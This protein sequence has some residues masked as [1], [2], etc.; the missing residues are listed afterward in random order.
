MVSTVTYSLPFNATSLITGFALLLWLCRLDHKRGLHFRFLVATAFACISTQAVICTRS[1]LTIIGDDPSSN[2]NNAM[3]FLFP[4]LGRVSI[5]FLVLVLSKV[6]GTFSILNESITKGRLR[7]FRYFWYSTFVVFA[8]VPLLARM[9]NS[10]VLGIPYT[11]LSNFYNEIDKIVVNVWIALAILYS[12][13]QSV[14]LSRVIYVW[15]CSGKAALREVEETKK[16]YQNIILLI[17]LGSLLDVAGL[18]FSIAPLTMDKRP[19]FTDTYTYI[20]YSIPSFHAV[21]LSLVFVQLKKMT[22]AGKTRDKPIVAKEAVGLD[23]T[24]VILAEGR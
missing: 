14:Y 22:L 15:K 11:D 4:F 19:Q 18:G 12:C 1:V 2:A 13:V 3:Y 23:K 21:L 16:T 6:L 9:Y 10:F 24:R 5:L 7:I 17:M 20:A 8:M